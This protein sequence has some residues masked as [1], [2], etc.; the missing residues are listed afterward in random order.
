M[1]A[2]YI[3]RLKGSIRTMSVCKFIFAGL[4]SG[5]VGS[6]A[7]VSAVGVFWGGDMGGVAGSF[8]GGRSGGLVAEP[9]LLLLGVEGLVGGNGFEESDWGL[10]FRSSCV[11]TLGGG[12]TF[13]F[14]T[15]R[16]RQPDWVSHAHNNSHPINKRLGLI[17]KKQSFPDINIVNLLLNN[18]S[19]V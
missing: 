5:R 16:V 6:I 12:G 17:K 1:P 8:M 15:C 3:G 11:T 14:C 19:L 4:L 7:V 9:V 2:R 13:V 18:L 10:L